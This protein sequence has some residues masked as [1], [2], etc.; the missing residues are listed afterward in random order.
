MADNVKSFLEKVYGPYF[1]DK[2][3]QN[4]SKADD[5]IISSTSGY[6]NTKYGA[7]AFINVLYSPITFGVLAK[8]IYSGENPDGMR[9]LFAVGTDSTGIQENAVLPFTSKPSVLMTVVGFK[10]ELTTF[11]V[12]TKA[13]IK[14]RYNDYVELEQ[15]FELEGQFH[16]SGMNSHLNTDGNTAAGYNLESIDRMTAS[17]AYATAKSWTATITN[18]NGVVVG[19]YTWYDPL[20]DYAT[21][22]RTWSNGYFYSMSSNIKSNAGLPTKAITKPDTYGQILSSAQTQVRFTPSG[23]LRYTMTEEGAKVSNGVDVGI[24]VASIDGVPIFTDPIC[25][26]DSIGRVYVLDDGA[27]Y[28]S[29]QVSINIAQPTMLQTA[30]NAVYLNAVKEKSM[31]KTAL[32]LRCRSRFRQG[33]IRNL[34][35]SSL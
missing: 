32:E 21:S 10:E 7:R 34:K 1:G 24:G 35:A 4:L 18:F 30:N 31:Y 20:T 19:T 3:F 17:V 27:Q 25:V 23:E 5:P 11:E 22:D 33:S 26:A 12:T 6:A 8:D 9:L 15:I 2:A 13:L 29:P 28:G 14:A 16:T